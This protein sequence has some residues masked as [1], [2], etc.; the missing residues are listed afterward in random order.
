[1]AAVRHPEG[2]SLGLP[3]VIWS[4][5]YGGLSLKRA[6]AKLTTLLRVQELLRYIIIHCGGKDLGHIPLKQLR[7]IIRK[8]FIFIRH[9]F[10]GSR[11]V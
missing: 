2:S 5:G 11:V 6:E 7:I 8:L 9:N 1:M 3:A 10:P 4:Q